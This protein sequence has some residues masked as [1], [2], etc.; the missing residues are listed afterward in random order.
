MWECVLSKVREDANI[1]TTARKLTLVFHTFSDTLL[2]HLRTCQEAKRN[3]NNLHPDPGRQSRSKKACNRC[4]QSR[5]KC[6]GQVPCQRCKEKSLPCEYTRQGYR[7]PYE[8]YQITEKTEQEPPLN[9]TSAESTT[10]EVFVPPQDGTRNTHNVAL[11]NSLMTPSPERPDVDRSNEVYPNEST[12]YTNASVLSGYDIGLSLEDSDWDALLN[13]GF[14]TNLNEAF[15]LSVFPASSVQDQIR[16]PWQFTGGLQ[17]QQIDSVEGKCVAIRNYIQ[18]LPSA[19][20]H[21]SIL[22]YI[23]RD[24][25]VSSIQM[26]AKHYQSIVPILHLP[27]FELTKTPPVLLLSMMLIGSCYAGNDIPAAAIIQ[28]AMGVLLAIESSQVC[29]SS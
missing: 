7:D 4:A 10:I 14:N 18:S 23:T 2:R 15:D 25:L 26:Y 13:Q 5:L 21:N 27:T 19:F 12:D 17:L 29:V 11:A 9:E 3:S 22:R 8:A 1:L 28:C 6:D 20:G 16:T 24:R